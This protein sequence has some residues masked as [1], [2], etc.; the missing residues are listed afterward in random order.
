MVKSEI[1]LRTAFPTPSKLQTR[2][3]I[4]MYLI[5]VL[6]VVFVSLTWCGLQIE[7]IQMRRFL[8]ECKDLGPLPHL[9]WVYPSELLGRSQQPTAYGLCS[10]AILHRIPQRHFSSHFP[11]LH[12]ISLF[13]LSQPEVISS[14]FGR[15]S[16]L[17]DSRRDES[18]ADFDRFCHLLKRPGCRRCRGKSCTSN[19]SY[20]CSWTRH[21][22]VG[23]KAFDGV[24]ACRRL[25][26]LHWKPCY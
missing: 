18:D 22:M 15:R 12:F 20:S 17:Q 26:H 21:F 6:R 19:Y 24:R 14:L 16:C 2:L 13:Q 25:H 5:I 10:L 23:W 3:R 1:H 4:K 8:E 7:R 11:P 9:C